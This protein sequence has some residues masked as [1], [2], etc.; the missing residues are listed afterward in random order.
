MVLAVIKIRRVFVAL[1][2]IGFFLFFLNVLGPALFLGPSGGDVRQRQWFE[3]E[4]R[5]SPRSW[6][7]SN[8]KK[9][10]QKLTCPAKNAHT[11]VQVCFLE[12]LGNVV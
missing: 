11:D 2:I 7:W 1:L 6:S 5:E 10:A 12:R 9:G 8:E 4:S 3:V